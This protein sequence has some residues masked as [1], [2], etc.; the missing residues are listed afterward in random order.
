MK[1]RLDQILQEKI[2]EHR[3]SYAHE[4]FF[5]SKKKEKNSQTSHYSELIKAYALKYRTNSQLFWRIYQ[6]VKDT[7]KLDPE[8]K[9]YLIDGLHDYVTKHEDYQKVQKTIDMR[10]RVALATRSHIFQG[11]D[12]KME[13]INVFA[14][15]N[16][17]QSPLDIQR[18]NRHSF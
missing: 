17:N 7:G 12:K 13:E 9:K 8:L 6:D 15:L 11:A 14:Q 1:T 2:Q 3:N 16:E 5:D 18:S 10:E 4:A